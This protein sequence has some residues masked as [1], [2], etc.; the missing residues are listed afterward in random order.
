[1]D[2]EELHQHH[3]A[4]FVD[5]GEDGIERGFAIDQQLHLVIRQAGHAPQFW[6]C[7]QGCIAF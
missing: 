4:G 7:A 2:D 1:M 6:H 5:G 3:V